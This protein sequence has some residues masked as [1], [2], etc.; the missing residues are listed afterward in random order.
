MYT[1]TVAVVCPSCT[2]RMRA[3][4]Q[5]QG[6]LA[7]CPKCT[8]P[9]RV[10]ALEAL[11][12]APP[13]AEPA[14]PP[15]A[16]SP[17]PAPAA[18]RRHIAVAAACVACLAGLVFA[19]SG[20]GGISRKAPEDDGTSRPVKV[21]NAA[22]QAK[23]SFA[24]LVGRAREKLKSFGPVTL[25]TPPTDSMHFTGSGF[26]RTAVEM[27]L[28]YYEFPS[29]K[30]DVEESRSLLAPYKGTLWFGLELDGVLRST[31]TEPGRLQKTARVPIQCRGTVEAAYDYKN[32]LWEFSRLRFSET[33]LVA[34][35]GIDAYKDT[36]SA[37]VAVKYQQDHDRIT[38][39]NTAAD[40]V[41]PLVRLL[42]ELGGS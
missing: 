23:E 26:T 21:A 17:S 13:A 33:S 34:G 39:T 15:P 9:F 7:K 14:P 42:R 35:E 27:R 32:R 30:F 41:W 12:S 38:F 8:K 18:P 24:R 28:R 1:Q 37:L 6:K 2:A 29:L 22:D 3:L 5:M 10:V 19:L 20:S 36:F 31:L 11:E 4:A 40:L 25:P 16:S